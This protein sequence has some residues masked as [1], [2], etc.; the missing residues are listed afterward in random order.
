MKKIKEFLDGDNRV[1]G[2][3]KFYTKDLWEE[4]FGDTFVLNN[5][6]DEKVAI[7]IV[8]AVFWKRSILE[9]YEDVKE[10][11]L[12][13]VG[14]V[15]AKLYGYDSKV[16]LRTSVCEFDEYIKLRKILISLGFNADDQVL[17]K[18]GRYVIIARTV[19]SESH[20]GMM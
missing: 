17:D 15:E 5:E 9:W 3:N 14:E 19:P 18:D 12:K 16:V 8:K 2:G 6:T 1:P 11:L 20:G 7:G 13:N 10:C 4:N